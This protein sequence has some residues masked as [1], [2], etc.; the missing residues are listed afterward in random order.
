MKK[1]EVVTS[2]SKYL[3]N[4]LNGIGWLRDTDVDVI[5]YPVDLPKW[6]YT[7]PVSEAPPTV[8][9]I[10]RLEALKAPELLAQAMTIIRKEIP[11]AR[12]L[13]VG[14]SK[15]ERNGLPYL[16]WIKKI[17]GDNQ[18]CEFVGQVQRNALPRFFS[19]CR[20]L[21]IPS[22]HDNYPMVALESMAAGRAVVATQSTGVV[23]LL[24][25]SDAGKIVPPGD[26][27]GLAQ[28]LRPF[29]TDSS[30][31]EKMGKRAKD[32]AVR[33]LD[34]ARLAAKREKA[35]WKAIDFFNHSL[36]A[37][38]SG[39]RH[40]LPEKVASFRVPRKWRDWA[41]S[42]TTKT[43]WKHFYLPTA[44]HFL[45]LLRY[46]PSL[47]H[48]ADLEQIRVLDVGC[49]PAVSVLLA[50]L[51]ADVTMLDAD[52]AELQ[53]GKMYADLLG[54]TGKV[55]YVCADAFKIPFN[56]C[57]FDVV[58]NSGFLEHFANP[59]HV[60][61]QMGYVLRQGGVLLVLVPNRWTPHSLWIRDRLRAKP[62]GYE[63]DNM[64]RER[65]YTQRQLIRLLY[66]AGFQVIASSTSNLRRSLLDDSWILRH[67]RYLAMRGFLFR[68]MNS[69]DWI[70]KHFPFFK[71]FGFLVGAAATQLPKAD[72]RALSS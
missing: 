56:A 62:G 33:M 4:K 45:E 32:T 10:G 11:E 28:A 47:N 30:Y 3:V 6:S 43:P 52:P 8:L 14:K 49:T 64:G 40:A 66:D 22:W 13:F 24:Q 69:L 15:G 2:P 9:F 70:E 58:W 51:G 35:Y 57:T 60:L 48:S 29:L 16:E 46:A 67:L 54:V 37:K 72:K 50:Y 26:P 41:V 63:W 1:S 7:L 61:F 38:V 12:A 65:S 34:P 19:Q 23:E 20:V 68:L 5:S 55:R 21:A 18:G 42:E 31:A 71:H 53:K 39:F 59:K 25:I 36:H 44:R 27:N 17:A